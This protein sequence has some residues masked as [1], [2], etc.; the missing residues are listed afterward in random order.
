MQYTFPSGALTKN[1]PYPAYAGCWNA[2]SAR[3]SLPGRIP[4]PASP[5]A[6]SRDRRP[7]SRGTPH[8]RR[9]ETLIRVPGAIHLDESKPPWGASGSTSRDRCEPTPTRA[10][11]GR[12]PPSARRLP[13]APLR[14]R[15]AALAPDARYSLRRTGLAPHPRSSSPLACGSPCKSRPKT[16][17]D[18]RACSDFD[19]HARCLPGLPSGLSLLMNLHCSCHGCITSRQVVRAV[20]ALRMALRPVLV[21]RTADEV[22]RLYAL[23]RDL[24]RR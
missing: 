8:T 9:R 12:T 15:S 5:S 6:L 17:P 2:C 1:Q 23:V 13:C 22:V 11:P 24:V 10:H 3:R 19:L 14:I 20:N 18:R 4:T 7:R 21:E 16:A